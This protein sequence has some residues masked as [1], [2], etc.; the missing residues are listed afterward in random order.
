MEY[1]NFSNQLPVIIQL[2]IDWSINFLAAV[3]TLIVGIWISSRIGKWVGVIYY[4]RRPNF[5]IGNR[6]KYIIKCVYCSCK[7]AYFSY[8]ARDLRGFNPIANF[9]WSKE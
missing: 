1:I 3:I 7:Q 8:G 6:N 2:G 5:T 4:C 9:K